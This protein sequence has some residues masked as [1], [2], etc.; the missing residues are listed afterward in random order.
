M[1]WK[2]LF[3]NI[4]SVKKSPEYRHAAWQRFYHI[5]KVNI[6]HL[7]SRHTTHCSLYHLGVINIRRVA[8]AKD[9]ANAKPV[10]NAN[11]SAQIS[12]IL[13]SVEGDVQLIIH[14]WSL[15][16]FIVLN[17][18]NSKYLLRMLQKTHLTQFIFR[19]VNAVAA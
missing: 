11:Y 16:S 8:T 3:V 13:H 2:I 10:G 4:L 1:L 19:H 6:L 12:W 7:H 14:R 17:R 5:N 15:V 9:A 18:K